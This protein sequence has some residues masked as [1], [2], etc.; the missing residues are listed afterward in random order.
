M[1]GW[2]YARHSK[3]SRSIGEIAQA[4]RDEGID[5]FL[6]Y[7]FGRNW[8]MQNE[9]YDPSDWVAWD[10]FSLKYLQQEWVGVADEGIQYII[11]SWKN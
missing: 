11:F 6:V 7:E 8:E 1:D 2:Y 4:W 5:Y 9:L 10:A 3:Q